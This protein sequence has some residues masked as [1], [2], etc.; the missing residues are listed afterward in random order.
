MFAA[1][2]PAPGRFPPWATA[3][4]G[5]LIVTINIQADVRRNVNRQERKSFR[6]IHE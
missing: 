4:V 2:R 6:Q 3:G 1:G 5:F